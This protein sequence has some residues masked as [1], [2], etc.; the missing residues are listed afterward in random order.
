MGKATILSL[1]ERQKIDLFHSQGLSNRNIAKKIKRSSRTV[2]RYVKDPEA[3]G[4]QFKGRRRALTSRDERKI[5]QLASD[6]TKSAAKIKESAGVSASLSTVQRAIRN[7]KA[8]NL[9]PLKLKEKPPLNAIRMEKRLQYAKEHMTWTV[10][11]DTRLNDWRSVVFTNEKR[12]NLDGPDDL[13]KD[14]HSRDGGVMVWGAITFYGAI[15][16]VFIDQKM[17]AERFKTLLQS[18]FPKINDLFGPLPWI[19]Q[20]GDAPIHNARA[21]KSFI[22]S[23]NVQVMIR[24]PHS[25]DLNII[26][27]VW[28]WLSRKVFEGGKQYEDKETLTAALKLAWSEI[29]LSYINALYHS[30]KDRIYEVILNKGGSTQF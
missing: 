6:S 14:D 27:D 5:V 12:F 21:V 15:D 3:Y 22:T 2:D 24:P 20:K 23:E 19:F 18:V 1:L 7:A 30:M 16:L 28:G 26:E 25:P 17:T 11:S 13:R 10:Q 29:S 8:K 9:D 4:S